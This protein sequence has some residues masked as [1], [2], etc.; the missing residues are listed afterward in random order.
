MHKIVKEAYDIE[1]FELDRAGADALMADEPYKLELI[2]E[3]SAN[4]EPVSFYKHGE[5][6]DL[7]AG[8]HLPD[9]GR[10]K[11]VKLIQTTGAYWRGDAQNKML[12]R[13]YGVA[14]PKQS[15]LDAHLKMLEE[16]KKRDH[17]K[18]GKE[19]ELFD[20]F[21][22]GPG[23]PAFLPNGMVVRNELEKFWREIHQKAGYVEVRTPQ[24]MSRTLWE[25]SGHWDH[26]KDNMY[27]T[28]IDD[29]DYCIK[30]MN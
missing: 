2:A 23:F 18:L 28:I 9:T 16:A 11:A 26:Y 29:M 22:E 12:C 14:F 15:E 5:F 25:N 13:V 10:V 1:R 7:C 17:R 21:D 19:L 27:T 4:G 20:I 24:I 6:T 30:P 8:P 3:H